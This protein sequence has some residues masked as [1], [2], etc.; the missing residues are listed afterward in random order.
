MVLADQAEATGDDTTHTHTHTAEFMPG[1][2]VSNTQRG[3]T[4]SGG[5]Q[6][7]TCDVVRMLYY[8]LGCALLA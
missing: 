8:P 7:T 2:A 6:S 5:H 4:R 1:P 3:L